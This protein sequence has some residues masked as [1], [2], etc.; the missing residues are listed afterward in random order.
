ML[1]K[2]PWAVLHF[3]QWQPRYWAAKWVWEWGLYEWLEYGNDLYDVWITACDW[4]MDIT[5]VEGSSNIW[6]IGLWGVVASFGMKLMI[7]AL[8]C[9]FLVATM[10]IMYDL[11]V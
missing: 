7:N 9:I 5:K 8:V 2:E 6:E 3:P 11:V 10:A 1:K 4:K